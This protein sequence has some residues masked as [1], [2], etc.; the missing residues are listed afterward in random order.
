MSLDPS[1]CAGLCMWIQALRAELGVKIIL[2][3]SSTGSTLD[4]RNGLAYP[5]ARF[6]L[7]DRISHKIGKKG[8]LMSLDVSQMTRCHNRILMGHSCQE[9]M[10][11][12]CLTLTRFQ[13]GSKVIAAPNGVTSPTML[14]KDRFT[15]QLMTRQGNAFIAIYL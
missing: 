5:N 11:P 4:S 9:L 8:K 15:V 10:I 2:Q 7:V 1:Y 6:L 14:V 3:V 12:M 13:S